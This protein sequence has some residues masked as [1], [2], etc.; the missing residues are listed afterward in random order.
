MKKQSMK[1]L[2]KKTSTDKRKS[3]QMEIGSLDTFKYF[4]G[5]CWNTIRE[6][7]IS[8]IEES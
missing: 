4:C 3:C 2:P 6:L 7:P 5:I 1:K 8:E